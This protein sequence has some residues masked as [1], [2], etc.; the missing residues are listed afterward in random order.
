MNLYY[1]LNFCGYIETY[2]AGIFAFGKNLLQTAEIDRI[3]CYV[4]YFLHIIKSY[5]KLITFI[6]NTIFQKIK[7]PNKSEINIITLM[8]IEKAKY[9]NTQYINTR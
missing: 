5:K 3:F 2:E 8:I 1:L 4:N 9:I 7:M 6:V